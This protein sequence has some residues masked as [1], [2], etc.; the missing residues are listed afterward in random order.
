M[1]LRFLV[2]SMQGKLARWL[3]ILGYDTKYGS[4]PNDMDL[5]RIASEESRVLVTRDEDLHRRAI[6]RGLEAH[7]LASASLADCLDS[8]KNRYGINLNLQTI[9]P[10]CSLCNRLLDA[11]SRD[12]ILQTV[13]ASIQRRRSE[14]WHCSDCGKSYWQGTH[15]ENMRAFL[16]SISKDR[17]AKS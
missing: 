12:I 10:R 1:T 2:D 7:F 14:F 13:P 5:L 6:R 3:R 9:A 11:A 15:W 17:R 16:F 4:E 8:L